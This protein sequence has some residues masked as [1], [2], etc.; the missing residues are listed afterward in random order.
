MKIAAEGSL[1]WTLDRVKVKL[2]KGVK[3]PLGNTPYIP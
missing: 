3:L 1:G 2:P